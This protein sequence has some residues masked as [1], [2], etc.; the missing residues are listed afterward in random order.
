VSLDTS[1][2]DQIRSRPEGEP[3]TSVFGV[4]S[5]EVAA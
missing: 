2:N 3:M 5:T 1:R 4:V